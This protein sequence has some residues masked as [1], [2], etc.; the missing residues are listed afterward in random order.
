M[1][2]CPFKSCL[3]FYNYGST[4]ALTSQSI[5]VYELDEELKYD[6]R[7]NYFNKSEV[8]VKPTPLGSKTFTVSPKDLDSYAADN[9]DTT[10]VIK[11]PLDKA[12]GQRIF[13]N[14][15]KYRDATT[16]ADSNFININEFTKLFQGPIYKS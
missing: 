10:I 2:P 1:T 14:A 11:V 3:D 4:D 5:S 9:S 16:T 7:R 8:L 6:N 12:F 13:D 15:M